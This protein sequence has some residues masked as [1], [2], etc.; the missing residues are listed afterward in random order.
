MQNSVR[1]DLSDY[2]IHFFRQVDVL[3]DEAPVLTPESMGFANL[4]RNE[5]WSALFMLRCAIRYQRLWSTWSVRNGAR[6][7][8]GRS[9]AVCFTEMPL[10]A[11]LDS[12][13]SREARGEAMSP[14]ALV[15]PKAAM[16]RLGANPVIYGLDLRSAQAMEDNG[17]RIFPKD[18]L[19]E[20]EQYR[21]VTYNPSR[22]RPIDWT[23]EREWR[24]PFR[25]DMEAFNRELE[26]NGI[27]EL[28]SDIPGLPLDQSTISGMGVVVKT[29]EEAA[30]VA[31][32]ILALVDKGL[33]PQDH[34]RFVLIGDE[35]RSRDVLQPDDLS[36]ALDAAAVNLEPFFSFEEDEP[37]QLNFR[38]EKIVQGVA[39][40]HPHPEPG[41]QGGVWL[42]LLDGSHRLTRA[43][44]ASGRVEVSKD[45]R[46]LAHIT[47]FEGRRGMVQ[48]EAMMQTLAVRINEEFGLHC[49]WFSVLNSWDYNEVPFYIGGN[50]LSSRYFYN[51]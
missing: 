42:W 21:Y 35:L 23:H 44:L 28:P 15:F 25:G 29:R 48:R 17:A 36:S 34:Y 3:S 45:G 2:L 37:E 43:L 8:Y 16:Y 47:E 10:A 51:V 12:A 7:I 33:I 18:V 11:F 30:W 9:P 19:P 24:W 5:V 49:D 41:E 6:T 46:Y 13:P 39:E 4:P 40:E 38:F 20:R 32:D 1:F 14:Y 26:A 50:A 22:K 27:V 31:A